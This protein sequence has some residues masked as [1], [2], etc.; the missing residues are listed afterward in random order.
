MFPIRNFKK[1]MSLLII[2][3]VAI[4]LTINSQ[5]KSNG[6]ITEL[7]T[8]LKLDSKGPY[9]AI[10][11]FCPDGSNVPPDQRCPEPGGV[12][13][14]QYKDVIVSLAKTNK[15]YLGQI[16]SAT[17]T[18]QFWDIENQ[19]SRLKQYQIEKYLQLIDDGWINRKAKYYRG[20]VQEEDEQ[21]WGKKF[22]LELLS[23]DKNIKEHFFLLRSAAADI[24]HKG[25]NK[26]SELVRAI[27]KNLSDSIPSFMNI[28]IKIHG[29]PEVMDIESVKRFLNGNNSKITEV[30]R[31]QFNKLIQEMQIT[32]APIELK[33]LNKFL[34]DLSKENEVKSNVKKFVDQKGGGS[35]NK[36]A[37]ED[38]KQISKF[39][40]SIRTNFLKEKKA[41]ARLALLDLS[42]SLESILFKEITK[43]QPN[44]IK[45]IIE[46]NYSLAESLVGA[47]LIELWEWEKVKNSINPPQEEVIFVETAVKLTESSKRIIDWSSNTIRTT[48]SNEL[49]LFSGFEPLTY[50]FLDNKIRSSLLLFYG[51]EV[52]RLNE[53]VTNKMGQKN[54]VLNLSNQNQIKGLN[55]GYA[56]GELVVVKGSTEHIDFKSDKIYVFEKPISD[57]KPVAGLATVSEG[58]LVSHVQ[59]LARNLGIP[60]ASMSQENLNELTTY[61]G[62]KI[63][64]AVSAKGKVVIKLENEMNEQEKSLFST[65]KEMNEIFKVPTEKLKLDVNNVIN[66]R[67]LRAKDSGVLCGPKAANLGQLKAMFPEDVVEGFV[68]PFGI[69]KIHMDQTIP[70]KSTTY[71][72]FLTETFKKKK[73]LQ[74]SGSSVSEIEEYTLKKLKEMQDLIITMPLLKS[75]ENDIDKNFLNVFASKIGTVG[76]FL[77]SDTNMEDLKDFTGAG[78]NLTLFNVLKRE[79]I[80][81]GI[82]QV[83][84]SPFSERSY[85]WRQRILENPE[86]V[87]PSIL[88]IP[89]VNVDNSGVM[90]TTGVSS[91]DNSDITIAFSR[92]P[93]G[94]VDGQATESYL[95]GSKGK[96]T[97]LSPSREPK[98]NI[99]P[100]TGGVDKG[101]ASYDKSILSIEQIDKLFQFSKEL[102][103][104]LPNIPGIES[105][106]P[107]DVE[108]GFN[109]S[110]IWLFQVRPFVESK[111]AASSGYL[112]ALDAKIVSAKTINLNEKI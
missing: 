94:A 8:K 97:L 85:R 100:Q 23:N 49:N 7:I 29:N 10:R 73:E 99:L 76:V 38:Y 3:I 98:Y 108:L 106:G 15:I 72:Q 68:I 90:I 5:P 6:E 75:F 40:V 53:F 91:G 37:V 11:W 45:E 74:N 71:W 51:N 70:G 104:K 24:P 34:K 46:K 12:Q 95:I 56:K 2:V 54:S 20:A 67:K 32:F 89:S 44:S 60:N 69:F 19:H 92:G 105:S 58:N 59:L 112:N 81:K 42:L 64:Y 110:K 63:F 35:N 79:E 9:K 14:G 16:L 78:L 84:A 103:S 57:L 109:D 30:Q 13:R 111:K 21:N 107:F 88:V 80:L 43:W 83:W 18:K 66:L 87:Y 41:I 55:P 33:T 22:L 77:R 17:D 27:S 82:K 50:G 47:G 1:I 31:K 52:G 48:Y 96:S 36:F 25:D 62:K 101:I 39:L 61:S 102:K 86:N 65:K 26:N 4:P 93:G 28:R